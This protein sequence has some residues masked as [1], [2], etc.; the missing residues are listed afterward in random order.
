MIRIVQQFGR[1]LQI[2]GYVAVVVVCCACCG[3]IFAQDAAAPPKGGTPAPAANSD[4]AAEQS[5]KNATDGQPAKT[6]D[7]GG[8]LNDLPVLTEMPLPSIGEL[9][10]G[11]KRDWVVIREDRVLVVEP[12]QP[13]PGILEQRQQAIEKLRQRRDNILLETLR[14]LPVAELKVL[15]ESVVANLRPREREKIWTEVQS[16]LPA[17]QRQ[18]QPPKDNGEYP[19]E[20]HATLRGK[21]LQQV[22]ESRRHALSQSVADSLRQEQAQLNY[23]EV[24]FLGDDAD[25][26]VY[27]LHMDDIRRVLYHED[28]ML[29]KIDALIKT[30]EL[31][32]AFE[33]LLVLQRQT[34][35]WPGLNATHQKLLFYEAEQ[36]L[37]RHELEKSLVLAEELFG[38]KSDYSGLT[39]LLGRVLDELIQRSIQQQDYRQARYFL[40]RVRTLAAKHPR[41][42]AWE[43]ELRSQCEQTIQAALKAS[44]SGDNRQAAEIIQRAARMWPRT[45]DLSVTHRRLTNRYQRLTVGVLHFADEHPNGDVQT[46]ADLRAR[47]LQRTL[48][49]DVDS[50]D[51]ATHYRSSI[52]EEWF[53]TKLGRR[54]VF[55]IRPQ[56]FGWETTPQVNATTTANTLAARLD[57]RSPAYDERLAGYVESVSVQSPLQMTVNFR[58]VPLRIEPVFDFPVGGVD[59]R[60]ATKSAYLRFRLAEQDGNQVVY[61]R[62]IPEASGSSEYHVA[63]IVERKYATPAL[64]VQGLL[65]GEVLMLPHVSQEYVRVFANDKRYYTQPA[66]LPTTHLLQ[67]HPASEPLKAATLRRAL[68]LALDRERILVETVLHDETAEHGRLISAPYP[69]SSFA[70]DQLIKPVSRD[71]ALAYSL[72]AVSKQKYKQGLPKLKMMCVPDPTV[73]AAA[74]RMI[75]QWKLIGIEVERVDYPTNPE[76]QW[77]EWDICY[78]KVVV[79]DPITELWPL[80]TIKRTARVEDLMGF[81]DWLRQKLVDLD[82]VGNWDSAIELLH[83]IQHAC[84]SDAIVIPLWEVDDFHVIRKQIRNVPDK[85][86]YPYQHVDRWIVP[87]WYPVDIP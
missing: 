69:T 42:I 4:A 7:G 18:K 17:S 20:L 46:L 52:F 76:E 74:E 21:M 16:E 32:E 43:K 71:I 48:L 13:R 47:H 15:R 72:A 87:S 53:P 24:V 9:I 11:P 29:R 55:S 8:S 26:A 40:A 25:G 14:A 54:V 5:A 34:P 61:Q 62:A 10:N 51:S 75:A 31:R 23:I 49:F 77:P 73:A 81:P 68:Q 36:H 59:L 80:L 85:L 27:R 57:P 83:Q 66:F 50:A 1:W 56:R 60:A 2:G 82:Y 6:E 86:M 58:R 84:Q 78:R 44:K 19:A 41:V 64:A 38:L 33:I 63:E 28:L 45:P 22:D 67:F 30:D 65:R 12:L 3:A 79:G 39:G 37:D 35:N 70:Y